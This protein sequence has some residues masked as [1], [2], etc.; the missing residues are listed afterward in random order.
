MRRSV[1]AGA[2][3]DDEFAWAR[4]SSRSLRKTAAPGRNDCTT[5]RA[6]GMIRHWFGLAV[7]LGLAAAGSAAEV[8]VV[9]APASDA[10]SMAP[11]PMH[12]GGRALRSGTRAAAR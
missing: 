5:K 11:L 4:R 10:A 8:R 6:R 3:R 9:P 7:A 1:E 2:G 12:V